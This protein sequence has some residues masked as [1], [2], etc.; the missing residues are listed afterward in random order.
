MILTLYTYLESHRARKKKTC[1]V[2]SLDE[3]LFNYGSPSRENDN[4]IDDE[5]YNLHKL[6]RRL[7]RFLIT[8]QASSGKRGD[9][10]SAES[11]QSL[12]NI[13]RQLLI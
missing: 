13:C 12:M 7:V 3:N 8:S 5:T 6:N 2:E 11:A 1:Q 9:P 10:E 4:S